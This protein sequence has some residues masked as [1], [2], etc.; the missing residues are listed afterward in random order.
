MLH[1][2]MSSSVHQQR[3]EHSGRTQS[4][5]DLEARL[6]SSPCPITHAARHPSSHRP[7]LSINYEPT[8]SHNAPIDHKRRPWI[9]QHPPFTLKE[10]GN[11]WT[12]YL[13]TCFERIARVRSHEGLDDLRVVLGRCLQEL[14]SNGV[15][16][17]HVLESARVFV[18][19]ASHCCC[20]RSFWM[21]EAS[22]C[23]T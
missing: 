2:R 9:S 14:L 15:I 16:R 17:Q 1:E 4:G 23:E 22:T 19:G 8:T 5:L 11:R 10:Q 6:C 13:R 7:S 18:D 12:T 3:R 20:R 21:P